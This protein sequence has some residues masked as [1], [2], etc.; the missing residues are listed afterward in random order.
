MPSD[1]A[2]KFETEA[3]GFSSVFSFDE[4]KN[5][6]TGKNHSNV[7]P[8]ESSKHSFNAMEHDDNNEGHRE[9]ADTA[10]EPA[11]G[12]TAEIKTRVEAVLSRIRS[13]VS[14]SEVDLTEVSDLRGDDTLKGGEAKGSYPTEQSGTATA[15]H[16]KSLTTE[17][18][19][20]RAE[21]FSLARGAESKAREAEDKCK[22]AEVRLEQEM[23][24]RRLA[25]QRLRE[26][27]DEY[28]QRLSAA[29]EEELR[30][31][32][33]ESAR[34]K[35][36]A[37]MKEAE[38]RVREAEDRLREEAEAHIQF[39]RALNEAEARVEAASLAVA[40]T[41]RRRA[42]ADSRARAAE[43][44]AREIEGLIDEAE[45]IA[46]AAKDRYKVA[47]T[48]L[49][50][51]AELRVAAEQKLRTLEDELSYYLE[52]DWSKIEPDVPQV[53]YIPAHA[54]TEEA[55]LQVKTQFE[56]EQKERIAA[57]EA[58]AAAEARVRE[59]ETE[60]LKAEERHRQTEDRHRQAE[61]GFKKILRKQEAELRSMSEQVTR[62]NS[63]T[64]ELTVVKSGNGPT[65]QGMAEPVV[66][67]TK[68][69]LVSY[70]MV[71]TLLLLALGWLA[72]QVYFQ[73]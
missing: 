70:G 22:E 60:L 65:A 9:A 6:A 11:G 15:S 18:E 19:R 34:E 31:L 24:Q 29:E 55:T 23:S 48:R 16:I 14:A 67:K 45:A 66:M 36:E 37:R 63:T 56:T 61:A 59:I 26:L 47:E 50:H 4:R 27:E 62:A 71:I 17:L 40:E 20:R 28:L 53:S 44:N 21:L 5:V 58:R 49:Q 43:E 32:D 52:V 68:M 51:E 12:A 1:K 57:E 39:E 25:E 64:T 13:E 7:L 10:G 3:K 30:R 42:E 38:N 69:K 35:A 8:L 33:A 54:V 41:E 72:V 73:L 2:N 46:Q